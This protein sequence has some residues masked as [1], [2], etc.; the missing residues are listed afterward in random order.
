[1]ST[2]FR[3]PTGRAAR[4]KTITSRQKTTP[5]LNAKPLSARRASVRI[6]HYLYTKFNNAVAPTHQFA[7][8]VLSSQEGASR[9]AA[10]PKL[11]GPRA[12]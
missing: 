9:R 1:M 2:L 10:N 6:L 7:Q 4:K 12:E 8:L 5:E 11:A 3:T